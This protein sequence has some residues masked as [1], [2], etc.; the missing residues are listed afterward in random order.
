MSFEKVELRFRKLNQAKLDYHHNL[1]CLDLVVLIDRFGKNRD[2]LHDSNTL[3]IVVQLCCLHL[4]DES[5]KILLIIH[6]QH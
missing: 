2:I 6:K 1:L 4:M 5:S 3:S